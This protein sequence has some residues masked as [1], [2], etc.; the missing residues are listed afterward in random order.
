MNVGGTV[1]QIVAGGNRTCALLTTGNIRCWGQGDSGALGY[2]NINDV[3]D[4]ETPA[5]RGD[6]DVGW[7]TSQVAVGSFHTCALS[8]VGN[9]RC[10]GDAAFGQLGYA[11]TNDV[12][13]DESP[14]AK[15][16]VNVGAPAMT[17]A[18]GHEFSCARHST[19]AVRCW[20]NA[21]VGQLGYGNTTNIGDDEHPASVAA[22]SF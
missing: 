11:N 22:L 6:I 20:G 7:T 17:I 3:G 10:W 15:G 14:A 16:D 1:I 21:S 2:G 4:N 8:S 12:G 19:G 9:V 5:S 13:D 18:A